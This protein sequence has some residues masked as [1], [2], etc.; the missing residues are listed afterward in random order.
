MGVRYRVQVCGPAGRVS[1]TFDRKVD[2]KKWE[3][4]TE[5]EMRLARASVRGE[6]PLVSEAV[7]LYRAQVLS[8]RAEATQRA[9][10][11][12]LRYWSEV[13][14][15]VRLDQVTPAMLAECREDLRSGRGD[16][17][18]GNRSP[19]TVNRYLETIAHLLSVAVREWQ[20]IEVS[21]APAVRHLPEPQGRL[22]FLSDQE[23]SR[24]LEACQVESGALHLAVLLSL[25]TGLRR[26]E[27]LAI[28]GRQLDLEER[29]ITV[30]RS[31]SGKRRAVPIPL[32]ALDELRLRELAPEALLFPSPLDP[33][34]P[35]SLRK[36]FG[37]AL[38][39]AGIDGFVW[40]DL[41]HT[42]A[43]YLA[44]SG[45]NLRDLAEILGHSSLAMVQRYSHLTKSHLVAVMDKMTAHRGITAG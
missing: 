36:P 28:T 34:R 30:E 7:E 16:E 39:R 4:E 25:T 42:A 23:R 3:R 13:L 43:S 41:R 26:G 20:V 9:K 14:G 32:A 11:R 27:L 33:K 10:G 29:Q 31:K 45:A 40:H 12:H 15:H 35:M 8:S 1:Q 6:A 19:S 22:R 44:M 2:A 21:P 24:L 37:R 38:A 5:R 17:R 18:P